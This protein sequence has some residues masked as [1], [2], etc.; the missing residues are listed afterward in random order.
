MST[1]PKQVKSAALL[2]AVAVAA[3][4]A[5]TGLAVT[6]IASE[7]G[8]EAGVWVNIGL[9]SLVYTG[10]ALLVVLFTQGRRWAR[11]GLAVLLSTI[12][13]ASMVV[14]PALAMADGEGFVDAF[15]SGGELAVPF[16]A[17]RMVHIAAVVVAT[18][19]MFTPSANAH[20][21]KDRLEPVTP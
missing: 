15:G 9:R 16:L 6:E 5:E 12:G 17:V 13:L 11:V 14:P 20:F 3:G 21:R 18:A 2:W 1:T 4:V 8:L 10:A 19:L 7:G